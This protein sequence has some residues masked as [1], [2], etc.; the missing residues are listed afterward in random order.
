[1]A[2]NAEDRYQS[3]YGLKVDLVECLRQWQARQKI[4][5]FSL[6][7]HDMFD[8]FQIP[9]KL[10]GRERE[11]DILLAAFE[12]IST[13]LTPQRECLKS[14]LSKGSKYDNVIKE[15]RMANKNAK[16]RLLHCTD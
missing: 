11:I 3:A 10:Y 5:P 16:I 15:Q 6:G 7:Q 2:K 1:M 12:R 14:C 13:P 8:R 4:E 9:Q